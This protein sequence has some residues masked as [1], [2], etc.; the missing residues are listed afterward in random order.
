M[1]FNWD[2]PVFYR[3]Y[4]FNL[5]SLLLKLPQLIELGVGWLFRFFLGGLLTYPL[6][7]IKIESHLAFYYWGPIILGEPS[8]SNFW[9]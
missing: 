4:Q 8:K 2:T 7:L 5:F 1:P 9:Q 6:L 3:F